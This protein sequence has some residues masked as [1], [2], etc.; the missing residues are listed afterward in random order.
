MD[1]AELAKK[2]R[3]AIYNRSDEEGGAISREQME[4]AIEG[5]LA[6][7]APANS[8]VERPAPGIKAC[9]NVVTSYD[10]M[11]DL[12][13]VEPNCLGITTITFA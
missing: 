10:L 1:H 5:A 7:F 2:I 3:A 8:W 6:R 4:N 9:G 12:Y 13:L 11:R